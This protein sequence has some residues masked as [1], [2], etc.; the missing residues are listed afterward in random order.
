MKDMVSILTCR[1]IKYQLRRDGISNLKKLRNFFKK[2]F[3]VTGTNF[4]ASF[5]KTG[6]LSLREIFQDD[7][8]VFNS[9]MR[10]R[11]KNSDK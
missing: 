8:F 11:K 5:L 3:R 7:V 4:M 2:F 10:K 1:N 6:K 9:R